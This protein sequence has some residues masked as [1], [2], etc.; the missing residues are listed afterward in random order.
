MNI[1]RYNFKGFLYPE[2]EQTHRKPPSTLLCSLLPFTRFIT[3]LPH[4]SA[5]PNHV[6]PSSSHHTYSAFPTPPPFGPRKR[7]TFQRSMFCR[8]FHWLQIDELNGTLLTN[9]R[10]SGR[11]HL[12]ATW[13]LRNRNTN[14]MEQKLIFAHLVKKLPYFNRY[15]C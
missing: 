11:G 10:S 15:P 7:S 2:R 3:P 5:L 13:H 6:S 14:I 9:C 12:V 1:I 4:R 8:T